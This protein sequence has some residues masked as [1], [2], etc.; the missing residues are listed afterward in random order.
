MLLICADEA[1]VEVQHQDPES[2][3][4]EFLSVPSPSAAVVNVNN[5][6]FRSGSDL[7]SLKNLLEMLGDRWHFWWIKKRIQRTWDELE[8][9]ALQLRGGQTCADWP[10]VNRRKVYNHTGS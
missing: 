7:W 3:H 2:A 4:R 10:A 5:P 9:A 1:G 6:R 8:E